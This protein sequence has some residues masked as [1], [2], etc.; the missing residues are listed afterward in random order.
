MYIIDAKGGLGNQMYE[1]ALFRALQEKG[2][3]AYISLLHYQ[4]AQNNANTHIVSHGRRFLL[5]DIFN[6]KVSYADEEAI[7]KLGSVGTSFFAKVLRKLKLYKKTHIRETAYNY[8]N[9]E[10]ILTMNNAFL[11]GYW[12]NFDY[13]KDIEEKL[14]AE[15]SFK[16]PLSGKNAEIADVIQGCNAVSVHVRRNDYLFTPMYKIQDKDYYM[17]AFEHIKQNVENPVFFCF[18]DD[19]KWCKELF[20]DVEIHFVDWNSG[21]ESY[22]DMQLMSMCRHNIVTNSTFSVWAAWL[23]ADKEK[24]VIRPERYYNEG[25]DNVK[26]AWPSDWIIK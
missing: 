7:K 3:E 17:R 5:E 15:L 12:Q 26:F 24:I 1:Y 20:R 9:M 25:Y 23:N 14:R 2:K 8:P 4:R 6:V 22:R 16:H 13:S 11:D 10:S 18:S 19:I 21:A